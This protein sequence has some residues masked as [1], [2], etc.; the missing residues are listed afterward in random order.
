MKIWKG[1]EMEG[2]DKGVMTLFVKDFCVRSLVIKKY[3]KLNPDC[4]RLYL[5][6]GRTDTL[7]LYPQSSRATAYS[8]FMELIRYCNKNRIPI[9]MEVSYENL[10]RVDKQILNMLDQIIVRLFDKSL[11]E[12]GDSD[13]I[14]LDDDETVYVTELIHMKKTDLS[15]LNGDLFSVDVTLYSDEQEDI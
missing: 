13:C 5:G 3:L 8:Q 15:T 1:P 7:E 11:K 10:K 9:I 6:A 4:K 12:L 14:K 2:R